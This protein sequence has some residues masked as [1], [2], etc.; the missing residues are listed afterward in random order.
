M[1]L[2]HTS[3]VWMDFPKR[4]VTEIHKVLSL[5]MHKYTD[6]EKN[7]C[8]EAIERIG[9]WQIADSPSMHISKS[10]KILNVPLPQF[11]LH[12]V[13]CSVERDAVTFRCC[14][15]CVLAEPLVEM[16]SNW[17]CTWKEV[18]R[19]TTTTHAAISEE[20]KGKDIFRRRKACY[21]SLS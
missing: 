20:R 8:T 7:D 5:Q 14:T 3:D 13:Y 12:K 17:C 21:H 10:N 1:L 15:W 2:L 19:E 11:N 9:I 4:S 18:W 16:I 6:L